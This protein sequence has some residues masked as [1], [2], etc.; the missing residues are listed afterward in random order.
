MK[1]SDRNNMS[2]TPKNLSKM[3]QNQLSYQ[4]Q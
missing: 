3:P 1:M 4:K 2:D